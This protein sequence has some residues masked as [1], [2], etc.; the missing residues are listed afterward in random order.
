[1]IVEFPFRMSADHKTEFNY[2]FFDI[3]KG[4]DEN[5]SFFSSFSSIFFIFGTPLGALPI[6]KELNNSISRRIK[7]VYIKHE[8]FWY[9]DLMQVKDI[10]FDDLTVF[11]EDNKKEIKDVESLNKY[12]SQI[13]KKCGIESRESKP[14]DKLDDSAKRIYECDKKVY[15]SLK[16][17]VKSGDL[18]RNAI[19]SLFA[20]KYDIFELLDNNGILDT[21]SGYTQYTDAIAEIE[22]E[23]EF[24]KNKETYLSYK[25]KIENGTRT[26]NSI[27]KEFSAIYAT[28][29]RM[30]ENGLL[31]NDDEYDT[32]C[33]IMDS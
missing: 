10:Q 25:K 11:I 4:F 26:I 13:L 31:D 28:L 5:Y 6:F 8:V 18:D 12:Y 20:H 22:K 30:D 32:Y 19:T 9:G 14:S 7:K 15:N 24:N 29:S 16:T 23:N 3:S 27:S 2:N 17:K 1:M 33:S 21:E